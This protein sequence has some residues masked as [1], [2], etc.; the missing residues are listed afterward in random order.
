MPQ[1][2]DSSKLSDKSFN[3]DGDECCS[4]K[5]TELQWSALPPDLNYF[6][7]ADTDEDIQLEAD[8]HL[9]HDN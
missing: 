7:P 6:A 1:D 4:S 3:P 8:F 9:L 5:N 2:S